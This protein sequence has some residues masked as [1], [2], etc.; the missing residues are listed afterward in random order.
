VRDGA[1]LAVLTRGADGAT[2]WSRDGHAEAP[3]RATGIVDTVGAGDAFMAGLLAWLQARGRLAR[4]SLGRLDADDLP[5]LLGAAQDAAAAT[6]RQRGAVMPFAADLDGI[7]AG[8]SSVER[9]AG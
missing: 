1:A 9:A 4:G 5:A 8:W 2:A 3:S 7:S 6:C